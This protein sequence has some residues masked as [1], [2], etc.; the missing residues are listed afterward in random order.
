M[1]HKFT[2]AGYSAGRNEWFD[3]TG[4]GH[5]DASNDFTEHGCNGACWQDD[6][7]G[8]NKTQ[9]EAI[10]KAKELGFLPQKSL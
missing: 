1:E 2:W 6:F 10:L 8:H 3:N 7:P 4:V 9:E 5:Y